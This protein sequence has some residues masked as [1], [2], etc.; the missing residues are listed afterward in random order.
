MRK[1]GFQKARYSVFHQPIMF[2]DNSGKWQQS[3]PQIREWSRTRAAI[4]VIVTF[5]AACCLRNEAGGLS[6]VFF[7]WL[8]VTAWPNHRYLLA[9]I[10]LIARYARNSVVWG[11][12]PGTFPEQTKPNCW[13]QNCTVPGLSHW[14]FLSDSSVVLVIKV[15]LSLE[16]HHKTTLVYVYYKKIRI[17]TRF[18]QL[19]E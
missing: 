6:A 4:G 17:S 7:L 15:P 16:I 3:W 12:Q 2:T 14:L 11:I 5:Q 18:L 1:S 13:Y 10:S 8:W 9:G 19:S